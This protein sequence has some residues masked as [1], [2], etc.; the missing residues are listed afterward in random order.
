MLPLPVRQDEAGLVQYRQAVE[1]MIRAYEGNTG[2]FDAQRLAEIMR[3]VPLPC[4]EDAED[5]DGRPRVGMV[6]A[7]IPP[8]LE[9]AVKA[10]GAQ[11]VF[12]ASCS[13]QKNRFYLPPRRDDDEGILD[14]YLRGVFS[15][16]PCMRMI[17]GDERAEGLKKMAAD[18]KADGLI[19]HTIKFCDNYAYEYADMLADRAAGRGRFSDLPVLKVETDYTPSG[20][21]QLATRI[22]AFVEMIGGKKMKTEKEIAAALGIDSGSTSTNAVVLDADGAVA[23]TA[24]VPTGAK[25]AESA[26]L[27]R[28][29]ALA[30]A[31]LPEDAEIAT[32]ATGYGRAGIALSGEQVTE[33]SCHARG[34]HRLYPEARTIID[35][36]GQDSKAIRIDAH[37]GVA[38]FAMN[39]KCAAGTGRFLEKTAGVLGV[40]L[41]E[42][43][44]AAHGAREELQISSMCTVFA[45]SEV[46]SLIAEGCSKED[47][48]KGLCQAVARRNEALLK[49]VSAEPPYMMTGGV[50]RNAGVVQAFEALLGAPV[51]V[52]DAPEL[53]GA[54]GAAIFAG[55]MQK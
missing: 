25:I 9:E 18:A 43:G 21:G 24:T 16:Y 48:L 12:N 29:L 13:G 51:Y 31:G 54:L 7:K 26:A 37:G 20:A 35:I 1:D 38:D 10:A 28:R 49:R 17:T 33:I 39:D 5:A 52:P 4:H 3:G 55:E 27:V 45:E 14:A 6:G 32:V 23:G 8:S 34:A 47:I 53:A 46:V 36:G 41:D 19:Y 2:R 40:T 11:V 30:A 44:A 15:K 42:I 22:E 50:A